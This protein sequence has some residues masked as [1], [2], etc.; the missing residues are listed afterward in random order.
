LL[1]L[2]QLLKLNTG[3]WSWLM[4]RPTNK[5]IRR[6]KNNWDYI[7]SLVIICYKKSTMPTQ[8]KRKKCC[9]TCKDHVRT[10]VAVKEKIMW[11]LRQQK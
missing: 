8:F 2:H 10:L 4:K 11:Y 9:K 5:Q 6:K 1:D 3:A 7:A